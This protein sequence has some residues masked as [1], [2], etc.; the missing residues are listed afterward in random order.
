M[1]VFRNKFGG[2]NTLFKNKLL[3]GEEIKYYMPVQFQ[4]GN[5]P[6][7]DELN[8]EMV[9][10]W[11]SCFLGK[12]EHSGVEEQVPKPK[13]FVAEWKKQERNRADGS[14]EEFKAQTYVEYKQETEPKKEEVLNF[15]ADDLPFY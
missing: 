12:V 15:D 6:L 11:G 7:E 3:N 14:T 2:W 5:E 8:I 1:K 9:R 13:I 4:K 10:W